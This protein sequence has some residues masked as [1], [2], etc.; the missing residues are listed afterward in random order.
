MSALWLL[1][2]REAVKFKEMEW[3][4]NNLRY[5]K[6]DMDCIQLKYEFSDLED[7]EI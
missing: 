7:E 4:A 6:G 1:I 5:R 3:C 2:S